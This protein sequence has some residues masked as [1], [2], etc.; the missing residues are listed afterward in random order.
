MRQ[1]FIVGKDY[2]YE[3]A[4][5]AGKFLLIADGT[6]EDVARAN[7]VRTRTPGK[8]SGLKESGLRKESANG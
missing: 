2:H 5:K 8:E 4:P 7:E 1:F 3:T 6:A